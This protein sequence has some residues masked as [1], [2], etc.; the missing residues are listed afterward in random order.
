MRKLEIFPDVSQLHIL[1]NP[2]SVLRWNTHKSYLRDLEGQVIPIIPSL[3]LMQ[4]SSVNL[5]QHMQEHGWS[6]VVIKPMVS[7]EAYGTVVVTEEM[8]A[9][10]GQL[11]LDHMVSLHD[12]IVQPF[13][14]TV[15]SDGESS[16]I[17]IDG[18]V[19]HAVVRPPIRAV[20]RSLASD[21]D[22]N[23]QTQPDLPEERLIVPQKEELQL[24]HKIIDAIPSPVLYGRVDLVPDEDEQLRVMEVE[25]VEP[26]LWLA[27][28]PSAAERF[29]DA[30][31]RE[32]Q[33]ARR[34]RAYK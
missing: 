30:I 32:V 11:Y 3:W 7:A 23:V 2:L 17:F 21:H 5:A 13:L 9:E 18:E 4:G 15:V 19:T 16:F 8:A 29:A 27:W 26:G 34:M 31:T 33:Q 1:W 22:S 14:S 6:R 25:L 24:V 20:S 10:E 28:M 12:M